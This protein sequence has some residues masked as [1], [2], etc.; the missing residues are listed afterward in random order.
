MAAKKRRRVACEK[1]SGNVFADMGFAHPEC[2][3]LK[4]HLT[5]RIYR[6]IKSRGLTQAEAGATTN[7]L[8]NCA[9]PGRQADSQTTRSG[10]DCPCLNSADRPAGVDRRR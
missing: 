10:I 4:A 8:F 2:E 5:L 7:G 9:R 6:I 3:R 1:S